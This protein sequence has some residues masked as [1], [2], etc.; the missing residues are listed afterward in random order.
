MTNQQEELATR[1]LAVEQ[2]LQ[3]QRAMY[4][5]Q[6]EQ[7]LTRQDEQAAQLT[8]TNASVRD[9]AA[10]LQAVFGAMALQRPMIQQIPNRI[11]ELDAK[12]STA[13]TNI[14]DQG[15]RLTR[16]G[17][18]IQLIPTCEELDAKLSTADDQLQ[19]TLTEQR[20]Q[21]HVRLDAQD[22]KLDQC[23]T[24]QSRLETSIYALSDR[25]ADLKVHDLYMYGSNLFTNYFRVIVIT[26]LQNLLSTMAGCYCHLEAFVN[27][28]VW[29]CL[30]QSCVYYSIVINSLPFL[31]QLHQ[32][33]MSMPDG[34]A[35]QVYAIGNFSN[36][37]KWSAE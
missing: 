20:Q 29:N 28:L 5:P 10:Q 33:M 32:C 16:Q 19:A 36:P 23:N 3:E 27:Y 37:K 9:Q 17:H 6:L 30:S 7:L 2:N 14:R 8:A 18:L 12:L 4:G 35:R 26:M 25:I 15:C 11:S 24:G 21:I 34:N 22:L 13:S 1:L 31:L